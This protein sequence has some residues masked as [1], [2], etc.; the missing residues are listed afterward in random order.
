MKVVSDLYN[1]YLNQDIYIIGT[2]P[3]LRVF[4]KSFFEGKITIGCN[5][6]WKQVDVDYCIT[7]HPDL[8]IP[9]YMSP[10]PKEITNTKWIVGFKKARLLLSEVDFKHCCESAYMFYYHGQK[11]TEPPNQPS[12]AGRILKWVKEPS[13]DNLYVYSSIS[14]AAVN[15]AANMGASNII[16]IGCDN[17]PIN[18]NHHAHKQHTRWKG[19]DSKHRYYQYYEGLAEMRPILR[20]RG[21]NLLSMSPFL[22]LDMISEQYNELCTEN[23]VEKLIQGDDLKVQNTAP[24]LSKLKKFFK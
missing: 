14:Q 2:G 23:G 13:E 11:N 17:A 7:I 5:M 10:K 15:L 21:I 12:N 24:F 6:A 1:K 19:V 9:E 3:S 16:L 4:P 8:N 20:E 18:N 22:K